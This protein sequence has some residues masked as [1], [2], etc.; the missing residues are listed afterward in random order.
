MK[1]GDNADILAAIR[2]LPPLPNIYSLVRRP[3]GKLKTSPLLK[4][5]YIELKAKVKRKLERMKKPEITLSALNTKAKM[6]IFL[7]NRSS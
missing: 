1:E 3:G 2:A 7:R 5:T 6:I 4:Y